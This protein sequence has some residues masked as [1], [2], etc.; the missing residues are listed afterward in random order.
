MEKGIEYE[1]GYLEEKSYVSLEQCENLCLDLEKCIAF[2]Y[3]FS[4][5]NTQPFC[6]MKQLVSKKKERQGVISGTLDCSIN[7]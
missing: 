6:W 5:G 4:D 7:R 1:G 3:R 2:T